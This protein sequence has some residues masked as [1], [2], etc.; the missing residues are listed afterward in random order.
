MYEQLREVDNQRTY[1]TFMLVVLS[2]G[3]TVG[4]MAFPNLNVVFNT[5]ETGRL[6]EAFVFPFY[7]GF[8]GG[9]AIIHLIVNVGLLILLGGFAEK[10]M[11]RLN[12]LLLFLGFMITNGFFLRFTNLYHASMTGFIWS[13]L[14]CI[15]YMLIESRRL[16]TRTVYED[17]YKFVRAVVIFT[18]FAPP[19]FYGLLQFMLNNDMPLSQVVIA[20]IAPFVS[21]YVYG[22]IA[23]LFIKKPIKEQLKHFLKKKKFSRLST[24][25]LAAYLMWL[26]PLYLAVVFVL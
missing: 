8:D 23:F 4:C 16:K 20:A 5:F 6:F 14:P 15:Q 25:K 22:F 2:I 24:D 13:M 19:V 11:G 12:F 3:L 1:V 9:T 17:Y 26:I 10:I 7:H 21:G 18:F